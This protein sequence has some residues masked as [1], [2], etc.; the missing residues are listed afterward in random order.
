MKKTIE[1]Y[2]TPIYTPQEFERLIIKDKHMLFRHPC[3]IDGF[4][5]S[6]PAFRKW[7]DFN[8]L[9]NKF[10]HLTANAAAPQFITH[11]RAKICEVMTTYKK[12]LDYIENPN[13]A[14]V[15]FRNEWTQG[16]FD[17]FQKMGIPLYCGNIMFARS[18][19]DPIIEDIKPLLPPGLDCWNDEIPFYYQLR[20]HFW[21]YVSLHG[22]LTPL[23]SDSNSVT[24]YLAQLKGSKKAI[25]YS[26]DDK[27]HYFNAGFGFMNPLEINEHEFPTWEKATPWSAE[28]CPGQMLIYGPDWAHH[29]VTTQNSITISFDLVN[30]ENLGQFCQSLDWLQTLGEF[31]KK[32]AALLVEQDSDK[33]LSAILSKYSGS[34]LGKK[35]MIYILEK[36]LENKLSSKSRKVKIEMLSYLKFSSKK[37]K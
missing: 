21:L 22:A 17:E 27:Q 16:D 36:T 30:E 6:W 32:N 5:T 7:Q 9:K 13:K 2:E 1:P 37:N 19:S 20:N 29:V 34:A 15:L 12:Y 35:L 11:K 23:H 10:G 24:T 25:L 3:I 18:A 8:Y 31:A 4:I 33:S 14:E 28:L 26:P